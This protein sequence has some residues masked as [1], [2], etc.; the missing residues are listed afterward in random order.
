[1]KMGKKVTETKKIEIKRVDVYSDPRFSRK[2]L[3]Q[4]GAFLIDGESPCEVEIINRDT[5]VIHYDDRDA[6]D[7]IIEQ[8]RFFAEHIIR[9]YDEKG[10]LVRSFPEKEMFWISLD[11]IRPTQFFVDEEKLMAVQDF[12]E[13]PEDVIVPLNR[14][15]GKY[16]SCDGHTRMY[17]AYQKGFTQIRAFL[18]ES[19]EFLRAFAE[20]AA[21]RQVKTVQD[22][23]LLPHEE[24]EIKWNQFCEEFF[25]NLGEGRV[26]N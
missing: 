16:I 14:Y 21:K 25:E 2:V 11:E 9:F 24:Y 13:K 17:A 3:K 8:F 23:I 22:M 18:A 5:A 12:T 26:K 6:Y 15:E 7:E 1:M 10:S 4:H 19:N 20:E